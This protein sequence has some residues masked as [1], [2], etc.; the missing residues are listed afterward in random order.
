MARACL[1]MRHRY[2]LRH[3]YKYR[4]QEFR[5][6]ISKLKPSDKPR[7]WYFC[8]PHHVNLGDRAQWVCIH[9]WLQEQYP[10]RELVEV[11]SL[12]SL[13]NKGYAQRKIKELVGKDD[14]FYFHSGYNFT[15]ESRPEPIYNWLTKTFVNHKFVFMP[16]TFNFRNEKLRNRSKKR[17]G[18][19]SIVIVA[20]DNKSYQTA[21]EMYPTKRLIVCPDV[22][23]TMIGKYEFNEPRDGVCFCTRVDSEKFYSDEQINALIAQFSDVRHEQ[24]D[25]N[26]PMDNHAD[27]K[28]FEEAILTMARKFASYKCV[29]TDRFHGTIFSLVANTPVIVLKTADHKVTTGADWFTGVFPDFVKKA[30]DLDDAARLAK[31]YLAG[32]VAQTQ[33]LTDYFSREFYAKLKDFID[34]G[35]PIVPEVRNSQEPIANAAPQSSLPIPCV[36]EDCVGCGVCSAACPF[37]A[38]SMTTDERGFYVPKV[39]DD[40]CKHCNKCVK[41]CPGRV[42]PPVENFKKKVRA[43]WTKD[44]NV[45]KTSTSGGLFWELGSAVLRENGEV[46]GVAFDDQIVPRHIVAR[47]AETL[48]RLQGSKYLQSDAAAC[49][50]QVKASLDA[51]TRVL[52]TGTPCQCAALRNYLQRD[53]DNLVL[54][55]F[56]CHG[57]PS[58]G[59][60]Q[61]YLQTY[62]RPKYNA[63]IVSAKFRV[64][65]S[66]WS[67]SGNEIK[68]A[69]GSVYQADFFHDPYLI[70]FTRNFS[71]N[72]SCYHCRY[73]NMARVADITVSDFW[74]Y[75]SRKFRFR[76]TNR[77]IS[78]AM[79]NTAKGEKFLLGSLDNCVYTETSVREGVEGNPCLSRSFKAAKKRNEFWKAYLESGKD[80]GKC[81]KEFFPPR[82]KRKLGAL[83]VWINSHMWLLPAVGQKLF[84]ALKRRVKR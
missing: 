68:F 72:N 38:I 27:L 17:Y 77:G 60:F 34:N 37:G 30:E 45:R 19:D 55:D 74:G 2:Q 66:G 3:E 12:G 40:K 83:S 59:L 48:K 71:L 8:L 46:W 51:G 18:R 81:A 1:H 32:N 24:C 49:Y 64:K 65:L 4:G 15:G 36:R 31:E 63:D 35:T 23:T 53:Y 42:T 29:V 28:G 5:D 10:D 56:V 69:D 6:M 84:Y 50:P 20:R 7:V 33:K 47:D 80:F 54:M 58:V 76:N 39:D 21:K 75:V 25:T 78:M 13:A 26:V 52:F 22:V 61:S 57:A 82:K 62:I 79:T 41:T 16:T 73:A 44:E 70:A 11:F 43:V 67:G 9:R 14:V